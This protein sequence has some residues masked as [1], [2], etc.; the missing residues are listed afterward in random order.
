[1]ISFIKNHVYHCELIE[2]LS[3]LMLIQ[4][5]WMI[6]ED[7]TASASMLRARW[8][9]R[10]PQFEPRAGH[11]RST[12]SSADWLSSQSSTCISLLYIFISPFYS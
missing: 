11:I 3:F 12:F 1:M 5:H 10:V 9:Q 6:S 7:N 8:S 4:A 2:L